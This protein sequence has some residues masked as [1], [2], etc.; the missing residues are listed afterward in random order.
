MNIHE[1]WRSGL[2]RRWHSNPDMAST[3]QTNAQHQWG[4]A[5]LAAHLFPDDHQVLLAAILH[6]VSEVNIGDVSGLAKYQNAELKAA[7]DDAE[8]RN[9]SDLGVSYVSSNKLKLIDMLEAYLW[10]KHHNKSILVGS[11]WPAQLSRMQLIAKS[12]CVSIDWI[13]K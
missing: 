4:C 10:V 13:L 5:V 12:L 7:I 1:V 9:A 8:E 11:G 3:G 2:V 6:D